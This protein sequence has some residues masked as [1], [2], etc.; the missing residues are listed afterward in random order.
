MNKILLITSFTHAWLKI[1][2]ELFKYIFLEELVLRNLRASPLTKP[3]LNPGWAARGNVPVLKCFSRFEV[4]AHIKDCEQ[5]LR[6]TGVGGRRL[7]C[8]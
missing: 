7:N 3:F 6:G 8:F 1:L 2:D 5:A 4:R